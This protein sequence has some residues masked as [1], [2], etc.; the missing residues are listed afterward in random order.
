MS[1]VL[2]EIFSHFPELSAVPC[3][4]R[5]SGQPSGGL[6]NTQVHSQGRAP[7]KSSRESTHV[8]WAAE[9]WP[10]LILT[11]AIGDEHGA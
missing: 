8:S 7:G 3:S 11:S 2:V 9:C 4:S 1:Q 5:L 10:V 6:A